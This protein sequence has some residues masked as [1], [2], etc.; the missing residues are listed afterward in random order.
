M[1]LLGHAVLFAAFI[2]SSRSQ[3]HELPLQKTQKVDEAYAATI[4][5]DDYL[6]CCSGWKYEQRDK[7]HFCTMNLEGVKSKIRGAVCKSMKGALRSD[8]TTC[9][10]NL[11]VDNT[12]AQA[13]NLD[14]TVK[15]KHDRVFH[16][17]TVLKLPGDAFERIKIKVR[18]GKDDF[19]I[20][21]SDG[22]NHKKSS[23]IEIKSQNGALKVSRGKPNR[24]K[25]DDWEDR[26]LSADNTVFNDHLN[27]IEII[28]VK[29]DVFFIVKVNGRELRFEEDTHILSQARFLFLFQEQKATNFAIEEFDVQGAQRT[30]RSETFS[31]DQV[32]LAVLSVTNEECRANIGPD[33]V[34]RIQK[35]HYQIMFEDTKTGHKKFIQDQPELFL[36]VVMKMFFKLVNGFLTVSI[37]DYVIYKHNTIYNDP[38]KV[39][40]NDGVDLKMFKDGG[41]ETPY[42]K[43]LADSVTVDPKVALQSILDCILPPK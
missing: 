25:K 18:G 20:R 37:E 29:W 6:F 15:C 32:L 34:M 13:E 10:I 39:S 3:Y 11:T 8:N 28:T 24:I 9:Q 31:G 38:V 1:I 4:I 12:C 26:A 16:N 19:R 36:G 41:V 40:F 7:S 5:T 17:R 30:K 14:T 21:F 23:V 33:L 2:A 42:F 22:A 43:K 27:T 35:A